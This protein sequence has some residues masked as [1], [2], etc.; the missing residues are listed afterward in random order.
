MRAHG[1]EPRA[2]IADADY[3][4]RRWPSTRLRCAT[5]GQGAGGDLALCA[6]E[7]VGQISVRFQYRA[8]NTGLSY[9]GEEGVRSD[10]ETATYAGPQ[11][12]R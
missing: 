7:D 4:G 2:A 8:R 3:Y 6:L 9:R 12:L 1:A 5:K 11:V 10:P